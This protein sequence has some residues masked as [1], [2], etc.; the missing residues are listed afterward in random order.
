MC[1]LGEGYRDVVE[2]VRDG[3]GKSTVAGL[4]LSS[5]KHGSPHHVAMKS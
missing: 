5:G 1:V 2:A 4:F 3:M